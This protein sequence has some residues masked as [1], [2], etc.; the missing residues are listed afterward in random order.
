MLE[1]RTAE[2]QAALAEREALQQQSAAAEARSAAA[3]QQEQRLELERSS[4]LAE[5]LALCKVQL[6]R[7]EAALQQVSLQGAAV[8]GCNGWNT[9]VPPSYGWLTGPAGRATGVVAPARDLSLLPLLSPFLQAE[10]DGNKH[11]AEASQLL[12]RLAVAEATPLPPPTAEASA[13]LA[14]ALDPAERQ[15]ALEL[16]HAAQSRADTLAEQN[17]RLKAALQV[18]WACPLHYCKRR[19]VHS[20]PPG[21]HG[22]AA[23]HCYR[24]LMPCHTPIAPPSPAFV[25]ELQGR[26]ASLAA[27]T[28]AP[29]PTPEHLLELE[30]HVQQQAQQLAALQAAVQQHEAA[31]LASADE[32]QRLQVAAAL[33]EARL[34]DAEQRAATAEQRAAEQLTGKSMQG[35]W[36]AQRRACSL[37]SLL[38]QSLLAAHPL[39]YMPACR[40]C[41]RPLLLPSHAAFTNRVRGTCAA[42]SCC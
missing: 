16:L 3:E 28:S 19:A 7:L 36:R 30:R 23:M 40:T 27:T 20:L 14:A 15:P 10:T 34:K 38:A 13:A 37:A 22:A 18:R 29:A 39:S 9:A 5:Q 31:A 4:A 2:W 6:A 1:G 17:A 25:Q 42:G 32:A 35:G 26:L 41:D 12:A 24:I 8:A 11:K 33:L 21:A